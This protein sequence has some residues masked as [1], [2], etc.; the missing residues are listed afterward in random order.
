MVASNS[1]TKYP[2]LGTKISNVCSDTSTLCSVATV[3][4]TAAPYLN[5]K[6]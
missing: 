2:S 6:P 1:D 5:P 3:A 4:S